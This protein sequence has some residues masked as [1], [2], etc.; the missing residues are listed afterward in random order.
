[1]VLLF[2]LP[3]QKQTN[4]RFGPLIKQHC[5][6]QFVCTQGSLKFFQITS[7]NPPVLPKLHSL[8]N[9]GFGLLHGVSTI[10]ESSSWTKEATNQFE[11]RALERSKEWVTEKIGF[12]RQVKE[13]EKKKTWHEVS[14][15]GKPQ[16]WRGSH[17]LV[18][19]K[20]VTRVRKPRIVSSQNKKKKKRYGSN[21]F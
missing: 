15:R 18:A 12:G 5:K 19:K 7:Q 9:F 2:Q 11:R 17:N 10:S 3:K 8:N 4:K 1:M 13:E 6:K 20:S 16:S 21:T 14:A